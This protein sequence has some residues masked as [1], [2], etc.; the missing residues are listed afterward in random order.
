[1]KKT[2]LRALLAVG[3]AAALMVGLVA[4]TALADDGVPTVTYDHSVKQFQFTNV[5]A[6]SDEHGHQ[7]PNLFR[8]LKNLMPGDA[9]SQA[10]KVKVSGT[11]SGSVNM[12]LKVEP[13]GDGISADEKLDYAEL[14]DAEGVTLTV[15]QGETVL[16]EG[17]LAEGVKLGKLKSS[18]TL[19][20]SVTL[21]IPLT[22]GNGLQGLQGAVAWV[23]TAEYIPGGGGG[24]GGGTEI[25]ET[26]PPLGPLPELEKGDHFAYIIGRDDG[27]VHP[28]AEITRAEV[29][30]IFFR[31]LTEDSRGRYWSQSNSYGD[32]DA[33][34]W[35][36]NAVSTLSNAGI[37]YGKPGNLFDPD[38]S[39]TRAEFAAI[40][41]RFFGGEYE[42]EDQFSDIGG[43]WANNEIN[44]AYMNN[45][46]KGYTDGTFRPDND[47]TRAEAITIINRVLERAPHKDYLLDDMITWPDNTDTAKWYYADVQEATNSHN[48]DP[49]YDKDGNVYEI[50]TELRPVRDWAALERAWSEANSSE[51]PG[52]V[53]SSN[54]SSVFGD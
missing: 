41:V 29:A 20:L 31:L 12:Y 11:G 34:A 7:Y 49:K 44:R 36:N 35:Y 19:D 42:G 6:Y 15:K 1:M 18:D 40:A 51:S 48:Y 30:T 47:I 27:L 38:A 21:N 8:D 23:F 45:L 43:H 52:E 24:G 33:G 4:V 13:E 10:I 2:K 46:V 14:L 50:W 37:L 28:E 9:V 25:P 3:L 5:A 16:A 22:A 54:T 53:V 39:I 26:N 32:V 17:S